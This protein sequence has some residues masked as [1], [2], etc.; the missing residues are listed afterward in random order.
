MIV[1]STSEIDAHQQLGGG[2]FV[3][4]K[5]TDDAGVVYTVG[6]YLIPDGFNIAARLAARALEI[7][8]QLA[9]SEADANLLRLAAPILRR[10][11]AA[12]FAAR[13]WTR[14]QAAF[15][16]GDKVEMARLVWWVYQ[17]IQ[18]GHLTSAEVRLSYNAFYSK[19][20]NATQW[21]TLATTRFL[22][23]RDRYQS[24]LDEGPI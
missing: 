11:T 21:T 5:H 3:V 13:F 23:L 18:A 19:N 17:R 9:D 10:Q 14:L 12:Q 1:S 20:L 6:P 2:R 7:A 24:I 16:A 4:E 22:P 15:D 8:A